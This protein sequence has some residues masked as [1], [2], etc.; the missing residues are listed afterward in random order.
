MSVEIRLRQ[1]TGLDLPMIKELLK[2]S[3]LPFEDI[4]QKAGSMFVAYAHSKVIGIGGLEVYGNVGLLRS[5]VVEESIRGKGYGKALVHELT[6]NAELVGVKELYLLTTSA[7]RFFAQLGFHKVKRNRAP[8]PI[9]DTTEFK[10]LC[11]VTS[12]LML[13]RTELDSRADFNPG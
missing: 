3:N 11:P 4:S 9:R 2:S 10:E 6:E 12:A 8:A 7:E 13:R 1:A 5:V